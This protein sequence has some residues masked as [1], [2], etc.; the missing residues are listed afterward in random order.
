MSVT[1][2]TI[3]AALIAAA[4]ATYYTAPANTRALIKKLT[5][6]NTTAGALTVTVHLLPSGGTASA[7]NM[8]VSAR[9]I[10]A[11][12]TYECF[13]AQGQVLQAGGLI[14]ALASAATSISIQGSVAEVV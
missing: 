10:G 3:T 4:A 14:Q 1:P 13:E 8:L 2:K 6:T 12:E 5:F 9:N 7:T 11:G